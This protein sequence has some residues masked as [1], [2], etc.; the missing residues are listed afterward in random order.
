MQYVSVS[1]HFEAENAPFYLDCFNFDPL[2]CEKGI[3]KLNIRSFHALTVLLWQWCRVCLHVNGGI[4][5]VDI[6]EYKYFD[7]VFTCPLLVILLL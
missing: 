7:Y 1:A 2:C 6:G 3:M 4:D 5:V